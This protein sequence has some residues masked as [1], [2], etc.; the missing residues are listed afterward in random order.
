[1]L[2]RSLAK[3]ALIGRAT[4]GSS[5]LQETILD[6]VEML[7]GSLEQAWHNLCCSYDATGDLPDIKALFEGAD[8]SNSKLSAQGVVANMLLDMMENIGRF[9]PWY[10]QPARAF[11]LISMRDPIKGDIRWRLAPEAIQKWED[12]L[13][14]LSH[15]IERNFGLI[16]A[17]LYVEDLM[18]QVS[19][20]DTWV[21]A[22]CGC[23]PPRTIQLTSSVLVKA[24]ILCDA[25]GQ[26]F[27]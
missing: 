8:L 16:Q 15:A 25:C 1:M 24:E 17:M 11:G 21:T 18:D 7:T 10:T 12:T 14:L 19:P 20:G 3:G 2:E 26:P 13:E 5:N 4:M 9:S 23:H 27:V 6:P 22:K